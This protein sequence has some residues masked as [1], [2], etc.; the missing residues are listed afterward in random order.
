MKFRASHLLTNILFLLLL[1]SC[2]YFVDVLKKIISRF[3]GFLTISSF[4]IY[5]EKAFCRSPFSL[6]FSAHI[7]VVA[8]D[9]GHLPAC[10]WSWFSVYFIEFLAPY[11]SPFGQLDTYSSHF[12]SRG[13]PGRLPHAQ[14]LV[15]EA[16]R[17]L[18]Q[19][20]CKGASLPHGGGPSFDLT[21]S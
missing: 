19:V 10:P 15:C 16:V 18:R 4:A 6:C 21:T 7:K 8:L 3:Y 1:L 13:V 17:A 11:C 12:S 9:E 14:T 2:F 20:L 5:A